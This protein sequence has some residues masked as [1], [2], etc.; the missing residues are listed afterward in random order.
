MKFENHCKFPKQYWWNSY[1]EAAS[2]FMKQ[3][4]TYIHAPGEIQ[5]DGGFNLQKHIWML[6]Q[7]FA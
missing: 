1:E 2:T 6:S 4:L 5:D 3:G 7:D